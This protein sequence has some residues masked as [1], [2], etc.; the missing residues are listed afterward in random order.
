MTEIWKDIEGYEGLYKISNHGEVWSERKQGLLKKGKSATGYYKVVLYKNKKHKNFDIHRLVAINFINNPLEKPCVNH[1]DENKTNNHYSNLEWC[2]YKE[3][4]NHGT[5]NERIK[6]ARK[7]SLK[8][9]EYHERR[10]TKLSIPIVGVNIND[11]E[12]I[13]FLSAN[14]AGRNGYH[15]SSIWMC[16]NGRQS[17]HKG[18]KWFYKHD[19]IQGVS[20]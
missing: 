12:I 13:E 16:M 6:E 18:Y 20:K 2:T 14:E 11:G 4:M 10:K 1:M 3:N 5:R 9:K 8:W 19:Y 15:Q 17:V 7:D